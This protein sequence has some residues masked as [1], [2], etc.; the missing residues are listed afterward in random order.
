MVL[1][2]QKK[3]QALVREKFRS[4]TNALAVLDFLSNN[5]CVS[6]KMVSEGTGIQIQTVNKLITKFEEIGLV[7][8]WG[9]Q[10]RNRVYLYRDLIKIFGRE[11]R[12]VY[13]YGKFG[14]FLFMKTGEI[15]DVDHELAQLIFDNEAQLWLEWYDLENQPCREWQ[16]QYNT[17]DIEEAA[18]HVGQ[19]IATWTDGYQA[20]VR[21]EE[22]WEERKKFWLG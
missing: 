9:K 4:T 8:R 19:I 14:E 2:L 5:P 18:E 21:N 13:V 7:V 1:D 3:D 10:K 12:G 16:A 20:I 11:R 6:V 17:E 15:F 22:L